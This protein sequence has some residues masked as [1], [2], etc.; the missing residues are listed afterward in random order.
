MKMG[1]WISVKDRLPDDPTEYIVMISGATIPTTLLFNGVE[2]YDFREDEF[3]PV[4]HWMPL[5]L[6]PEDL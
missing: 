2:W 4:T 5:P 6:P 3:Y 1:E